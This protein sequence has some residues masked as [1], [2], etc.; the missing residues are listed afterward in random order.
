MKGKDFF[1]TIRQQARPAAIASWEFLKRTFSDKKNLVRFALAAVAV[2]VVDQLF[3]SGKVVI[4]GF[5]VTLFIII[6]QIALMVSAPYALKKI[7]LAFNLYSY[8]VYLCI[9]FTLLLFLYDWMLWYFETS[10]DYW[11]AMYSLII[12]VFNAIIHDLI[13]N[14]EH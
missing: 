8:G 7:K 4:A 3:P 13:Y 5:G 6:T 11:V 9:A 1:Q 14:E 10:N 12:A 2:V